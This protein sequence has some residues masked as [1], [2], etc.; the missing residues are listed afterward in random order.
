[1]AW[2]NYKKHI[3][4]NRI[5]KKYTREW[6][7]WSDNVTA[8]DIFDYS[9]SIEKADYRYTSRYYSHYHESYMARYGY[10]FHGAI[11]DLSNEDVWDIQKKMRKEQFDK[12]KKLTE[13]A[14]DKYRRAGTLHRT[15][16]VF[17]LNRKYDKVVS[18]VGKS[19]TEEDYDELEN[20][21]YMS[22]ILGWWW[23]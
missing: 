15:K 23:D 13:G 1:M 2:K 16:A 21:G 8:Y 11:K 22:P 17:E 14:Y 12:A 18:F 3:H 5:A 20:K 4:R 9:T 19:G 6:F 7:N 10:D